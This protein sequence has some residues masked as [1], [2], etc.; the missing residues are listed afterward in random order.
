MSH[1]T[2]SL[3]DLVKALNDGIAFYDEASR[4][5]SNDSYTDV[6][7]RMRHLKAAIAADLNAEI[8]IEGEQPESDGSWLGSLRMNYADLIADMS[9]H[10]EHAYINQV[11][12]QEDRVVHA[13]R[14]ASASDSSARVRQLAELY[15]PEVQRMH[16][17]I[18]VLKDLSALESAKG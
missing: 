15:M 4:K 14:S 13:F 2:N 8:E 3:S 6:F 9:E 18:S 5:I 10:P 11:E 7:A 1:T 12:A 16:D 17:E